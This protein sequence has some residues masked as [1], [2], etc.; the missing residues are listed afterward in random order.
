MVVKYD[1]TSPTDTAIPPASVEGS[2]PLSSVSTHETPSVL[3]A[4]ASPVAARY[5]LRP[6]R[7]TVD[8]QTAFAAMDATRRAIGNRGTLKRDAESD[9][10]FA[11]LAVTTNYGKA[12]PLQEQDMS[13]LPE[14]KP[15]GRPAANKPRPPAAASTKSKNVI[16]K[17][18]AGLL[19]SRAQQAQQSGKS[20]P[21][22]GGGRKL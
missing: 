18:T 3:K 22:N 5:G 9:S 2:A 13:P 8:P 21:Q 16:G 17:W 7:E 12:T 15:Q 10:R 19:K 6:E 1:P 14:P 4:D 20:G 11:D